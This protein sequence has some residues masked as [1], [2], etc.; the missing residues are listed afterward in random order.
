MSRR[1][2]EEFDSEKCSWVSIEAYNDNRRIARIKK[3]NYLVLQDGNISYRG[4]IVLDAAGQSDME[5]YVEFSGGRDFLDIEFDIVVSYKDGQHIRLQTRR[6][7]KVQIDSPL[8]S[9][10]F[11]ILFVSIN[12][13]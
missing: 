3:L 1:T 13:N 7:K 5:K 11:S 10:T 6:L 9:N 8:N 12:S 2:I 4:I